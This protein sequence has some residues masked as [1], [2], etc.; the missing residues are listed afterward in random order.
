MFLYRDPSG[1]RLQ[2]QDNL[3]S[4]IFG[5]TM[6]RKDQK[7]L[8]IGLTTELEKVG[9]SWEDAKTFHFSKEIQVEED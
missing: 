8:V 1:A 4:Y 6:M 5:K 3:S 2:M 9:L 7:H